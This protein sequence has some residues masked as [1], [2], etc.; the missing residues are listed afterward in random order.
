MANDAN[1]L[2]FRKKL[3][4]KYAKCKKYLFPREVY[5]STIE[6]LKLAS[7]VSSSKSGHDYYI[8]NKYEVLQCGDV[9]KLIKK[10]SS[11]E[12]PPIY[13]VCIEETYATIQRA[14]IATGHGGRDRML[15]HLSTKYANITRECVDLFKSYCVPC[16][17]KIKRPKELL[18]GQFYLRTLVP[19][20]K[21]IL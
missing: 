12:D 14:H 11:P 9:E 16:Q 3:F 20:A 4:E 8:L 19:A 17:E 1:E 15:K 5:N 2:E 13:Y 21:L 7:Q 10:R 18:S 6:D